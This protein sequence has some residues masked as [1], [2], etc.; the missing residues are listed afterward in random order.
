MTNPTTPE[1]EFFYVAYGHGT[2][3]DEVSIDIADNMADEWIQAQETNVENVAEFVR[4]NLSEDQL[5]E[6]V[7]TLTN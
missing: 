1:K 7:K 5:V 2:D 6:L 3:A 4:S